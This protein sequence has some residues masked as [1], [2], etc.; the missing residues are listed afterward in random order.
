MNKCFWVLLGLF[1]M[2][3]AN[4][5]SQVLIN[6]IQS[7]NHSTSKDDFNEFPDW[8]ELLN[9]SGS[10]VN[11]DGW[12]LTD[13]VLQISKWTFPEIIMPPGSYLLIYAS[14]R[15]IKQEQVFWHTVIN[16]GDTFRYIIP[17]DTVSPNWKTEDYL[18]FNWSLGKSGFGY[19]DNDDATI[20]ATPLMSVYL[21]KSFNI[22]EI[23]SLRQLF[24]NV[25]YD[26][27][28]VAYINGIEVGRVNLGAAGSTVAYNQ[29]A[30][31]YHE[32]A[33]YLGGQPDLFDISS[34]IGLLKEGENLFSLEAHNYG[35]GSSDFSILP[36]LT[37]GTGSQIT[38]PIINKYFTKGT[39]APH[40]NFKINS[41]GE[42]I[43]LSNARGEVVDSIAAVVIGPDLSYGRLLNNNNGFQYF[44]HP[45]PGSEN[46]TVGHSSLTND[47]VI[48][49]QSGGYKPGGVTLTLSSPTGDSIFYTIDGS[50]PQ[51]NSSYF[52][53]DITIDSNTIVRARIIKDGFLPGTIYSNTYL[54]ERNSELPILSIATDPDNLWDYNTGMYEL[55]PGANS[56]VPYYGANFWMDWEYPFQ[57]EL[58]DVSGTKIIDQVVGGKIFGGWS[59]AMAQK[60]FAMLAKKSYGK[61][62]YDYPI[63]KSKPYS[64]YKGLVMRA[65]GNDWGYTMIRDGLITGITSHL[66]IDYQGFQP[67]SAYV[68]GDYWGIYHLREKINE[69]F[70]GINNDV[71]PD[72]VIILEG[73]GAIV[74]G[75]NKEYLEL[76]DF[77]NKNYSLGTAEKYSYVEGEV[78]I[79]NYIKYQL[80]QIFFYNTDWPSNNI[81]YWRTIHPNSKWRYIIYDTDFAMGLYDRES[82][83]HNSLDFAMALNGPDWPN[84]PWSTLMLRRLIT[85]EG[86]RN[87]FINQ[88]ADNINTT[89]LPS[90][91]KSYSDSLQNML[92]SEMKS[93]RL[94]WNIGYNS[95][96]WE[97]E[98][99][100]AWCSLRPTYMRKHIQEFFNLPNKHLVKIDVSN[101]V[102]GRIELNTLNLTDFPFSGTYFEDVPINIKA[103][104]AP[105]YKFVKWEG[106][107]NHSQR[108]FTHEFTGTTSFKAIF[109]QAADEEIDIV[110]NEINY[111]SSVEY[112]AGDW[113][114]LYNNSDAT[115]DIQDYLFTELNSDSG[116]YMPPLTIIEPN[117]YL[118]ICKKL[119]KFKE[120]YPNVLNVVGDIN[121]GLSSTGDEI[122]LYNK[123]GAV[124]DAVDYLPYL[125]WPIEANGTGATLELINPD[126]DNGQPESWVAVKKGG[127][128]GM[129][130]SAFSGVQDIVLQSDPIAGISAFPNSFADYTTIKLN[131]SVAQDIR[132]EIVDINGRVVKIIKDCYMPSGTHFFDWIPDGNISGG[133]YIIRMLTSNLIYNEKVSFIVP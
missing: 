87:N 41:E 94:R 18:D 3:S 121:F 68:N 113:V 75:D 117:D 37:I 20:L 12:T 131:L 124:V 51:L 38:N 77:L 46:P 69:H 111:N 66:G 73:D 71:D 88:M 82:Y 95:W 14:G 106:G 126:L 61:D 101:K 72:D 118:V 2:F 44:L 48:F 120:V 109:E 42:T 91:I 123:E 96:L 26:D 19:G 28:F 34:H 54:T 4:S 67:T 85:N 84:P 74:K 129:Q 70:I 27:A 5:K 60:S 125:P 56:N 63:F 127:T 110:I 32:A 62:K 116:F 78:D 130:N 23:A 105:G 100:N 58:Y 7:S 39:K 86:F 83:S 50:E 22:D 36:I 47:I 122:R 16:E 49:S 76:V 21:R 115:V 128:P 89:F 33:I 29:T 10:E 55:G 119:K 103:V 98:V 102:H 90:R 104:P 53:T 25:D 97:L 132:L 64:S 81:K 45:T 52:E 99:L 57:F 17:T 65:S 13:D 80:V 40:T 79:D 133:I 6:E 107:V 30:D 112:D 1:F 92:D 31:T 59:R 9:V 108:A 8:I 35:E 93:H 24:L 114:E 43:L 15:D 11:L